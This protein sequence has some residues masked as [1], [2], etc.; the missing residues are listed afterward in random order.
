MT[1]KIYKIEELKSGPCVALA[2]YITDETKTKQF[3]AFYSEALH[4]AFFT[5]PD[6]WQ[7]V[8]YLQNQKAITEHN[9]ITEQNRTQYIK[10][11]IIEA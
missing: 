6:S 7:V 11:N 5:I 10:N 4:A 8:G 1:Q 2:Q 9:K 3:N